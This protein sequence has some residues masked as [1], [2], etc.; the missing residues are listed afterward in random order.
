MNAPD[1]KVT[2]LVVDDHELVRAGLRALLEGVDALE[3]VGEAATGLEAVEQSGLLDPDLVLLDMRLPDIGGAEVCRRVLSVRPETKVLILTS[4]DGDEEISAALLAGASGY[5]MKDIPPSELVQ[6]ILGVVGGHT[7]LDPG[8]ARRVFEGQLGRAA[9]EGDD[10]ISP[11]E[12]EVLE[13]MARGMRNREIARELWISEPTVK[14]HV[15]HIIRK[16]GQSDRTQAIL[17]AV[18]RGIVRIA[19]DS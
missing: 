9:A 3:V 15:S 4:F 5:V 17:T 16:L 1:G 19:R 7:V 8:V 6:T 14:T 10:A 18:R 2:V 12:H 13:L 11:R